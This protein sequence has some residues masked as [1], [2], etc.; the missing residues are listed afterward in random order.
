MLSSD[1]LDQF[2]SHITSVMLSMLRNQ[3]QAPTL[4][5]SSTLDLLLALLSQQPRSDNSNAHVQMQCHV[6]SMMGVRCSEPHPA[7]VD[8]RVCSALLEQLRSVMMIEN[9][10]NTDSGNNGGGA[11]RHSVII[12]HEVL[13]ILMDMYGADN[14][15][16]E[17]FEREDVLGHFQRCLPGFKRRIK[18]IAWDGG[19][20]SKRY[21]EEVGVWNETALNAS[22]FIKYKK[23]G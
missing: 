13:N 18:K 10:S 2:K 15:H 7:S 12:T 9:D 5:D 20:K 8:T 17:V 19:R 6:I 4:V 16:E 23:G 21:D 3:P 14:C 11:A 1:T 22:R